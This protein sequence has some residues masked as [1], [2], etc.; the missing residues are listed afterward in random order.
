[1]K[2]KVYV[3]GNLVQEYDH[4]VGLSVIKN[5]L[6]FKYPDIES[7]AVKQTKKR[8]EETGEEYWEVRFEKTNKTVVGTKG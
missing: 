8:D 6:A 1:M 2:T 3:E 7:Y 4:E 5:A